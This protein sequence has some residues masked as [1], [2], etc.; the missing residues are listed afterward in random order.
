MKYTITEFFASLVGCPFELSVEG[1]WPNVPGRPDLEYDQCIRGHIG[2]LSRRPQHPEL[3]LENL[4][5]F[6]SNRKS[7]VK[8]SESK[9]ILLPIFGTRRTRSSRMKNHAIASIALPGIY[10]LDV[11]NQGSQFPK[12]PR[13]RVDLLSRLAKAFC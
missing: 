2:R 7:W 8:H 13:K 11:F 3:K 6:D 12:R 10:H 9:N 4:A 1:G 5:F